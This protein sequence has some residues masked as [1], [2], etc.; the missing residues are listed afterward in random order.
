MFLE[1]WEFNKQQEQKSF[2][3][4]VECPQKERGVGYRG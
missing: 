3:R 2:Y 4:Q 1:A